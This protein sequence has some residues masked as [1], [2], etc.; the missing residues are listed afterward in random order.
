MISD[1]VNNEGT[2]HSRKGRGVLRQIKM[3]KTPLHREEKEHFS[4]MLLDFN[5]ML[6]F[7]Y[8]VFCY[9]CFV[10][11]CFPFHFGGFR[12]HI[13]INDPFIFTSK[14]SSLASF[15]T[16]TSSL[17]SC[18]REWGCKQRGETSIWF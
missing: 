13:K 12:T 18:K 17:P 2:A 16:R 4:Q 6:S 10:W 11:F 15:Y 5:N 7:G 8:S 14:I 3:H 9:C 1:A